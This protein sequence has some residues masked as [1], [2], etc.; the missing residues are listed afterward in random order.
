M[1]AAIHYDRWKRPFN[2]YDMWELL[3]MDASK[4]KKI[5]PICNWPDPVMFTVIWGN[6]ELVFFKCL[7]PVQIPH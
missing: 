2:F 3:A 7:F 4:L 6:S 1:Y 5:I